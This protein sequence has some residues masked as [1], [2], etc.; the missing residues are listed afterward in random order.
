MNGLQLLIADRNGVYI[1]QQFVEGFDLSAF[2][3]AEDSEDV[4]IVKQ[5]PYHPW[6]WEA[7]QSILYD[8]KTADGGFLYQDG[9]LWEV[10]PQ[11][12]SDEEYEQFF[13]EPRD[14]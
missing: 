8:A 14:E 7:W 6:Y 4:S 10:N 13:G 1:P 3:I 9:D 11:R 5:G 12:M 2:G